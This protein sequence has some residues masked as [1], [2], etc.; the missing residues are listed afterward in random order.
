MR[1]IERIFLVIGIICLGIYGFITVQAWF[2]QAE[3]RSELEEQI[4]VPS[5]PT[6]VPVKPRLAEGDLVGRLEVP[7]LNLSVMVMEGTSDRTLRLGAG[8]IP[9]TSYPGSTGNAGFAAHRDTFFR[10]IRDIKQQD[11]V[12][13]TTPRGTLAYRVSSLSIVDPKDVEVL[14]PTSSE[15]ITLVTCYPFYY[16]G[17][18]PKRFVVQATRDATASEANL[19][20]Q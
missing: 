9:G 13:F 5:N 4:V 18:A 6:T 12:R 11:L 10:D 2:Q 16:I 14:E 17:P 7:R 1:A 8:H 19:L 3:L 20:A 15:T